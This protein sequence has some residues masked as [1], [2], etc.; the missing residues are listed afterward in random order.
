MGINRSS[1]SLQ[2]STKL[3]AKAVAIDAKGAIQYAQSFCGF[4]IFKRKGT[5][6]RFLNSLKVQT[7]E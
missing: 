7:G 3:N 4:V 6:E 2:V 1:R 5:V